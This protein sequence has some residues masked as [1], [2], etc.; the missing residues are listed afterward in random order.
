MRLLVFSD[1]H[2]DRDAARSLVERAA[3]ADVLIGA[4]DF[5][6]MRHG[7]DD[8]IEILRE[9][10]KPVVL[11]PGNGESDVELREACAGWPSAH[12]LHGGVATF[13][14]VPFYGIG[15]GIPVTPF[16]EWSF[17]F[18]DDEAEVMIV[19]SP[20]AQAR[21]A[22]E[23][24]VPKEM[25]LGSNYPNPFNPRTVIPYAVAERSTVRIAVYDVLGREVALLVDGA[26]SAG[27][28]E[29]AWEASRLPTGVYVVRLR[30]GSVV[31]TQRVTLMK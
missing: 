26:V 18:T 6:V 10:D 16:G 24:G 22:E 7:I 1:L 29:V 27:R 30:A 28:Y 4:G 23:V 12:V 17:D 14:G 8:V 9:V 31:K 3:E 5:A 15:G 13:A 2:R 25:A 20:Q 21:A 19:A 11:V